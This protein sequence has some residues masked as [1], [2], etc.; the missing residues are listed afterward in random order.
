ML[1]NG[2]FKTQNL[3]AQKL[4]DCTKVTSTLPPFYS[5]GRY[6]PW[7]LGRLDCWDLLARGCECRK[8]PIL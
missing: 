2:D 8:Y 1:Q 6:V 7:Q 5:T 3:I 4:Y